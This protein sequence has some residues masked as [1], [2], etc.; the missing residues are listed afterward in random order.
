MENGQENGLFNKQ[1]WNGRTKFALVGASMS[2]M[3]AAPFDDDEWVICSIGGLYNRLPIFQQ[4]KVPYDRIAWFEIHHRDLLTTQR[5]S[6]GI[7]HTYGHMYFAWMRDFVAAGGHLVLKDELEE[8]PGAVAFDR[9]AAAEL[10]QGVLYFTNSVSYMIA[11]A[12][13]QGATDIGYWGID[14]MHADNQENQEYSYQRPSCEWWMGLA[15][16]PGSGITMHL[17]DE[18][19]MLKTAYQYGDREESV[20]RNRLRN[21]YRMLLGQLKQEEQQATQLVAKSAYKKG[22]VSMLDWMLKS[23]LPGESGAETGVAPFPGSNKE[24]PENHDKSLM[25]M[26]TALADPTK[27]KAIREII[28]R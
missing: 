23:H 7:P 4:P 15:H 1:G 25:K 19:D 18:S 2:S 3:L 26:K 27:Q 17:P 28:E 20:W 21:R 6:A 22:Q 10:C 8:V 16:G 24:R 13:M 11:W 5:E 9:E 14:M 12:M